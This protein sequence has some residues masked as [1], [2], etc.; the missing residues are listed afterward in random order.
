MFIDGWP[1][2][3]WS[4]VDY[5]RIPK[6]GFYALKQA[7][8]P[9]LI[10]IENREEKVA[11]GSLAN[12][13]ISIVNDLNK[14]FLA[15]NWS[16]A[17]KDPQGKTLDEFRGEVNVLMDFVTVL[18]DALRPNCIWRVPQESE[19]GEYAAE[20]ELVSAQ[21]EILSTNRIFFSVYSAPGWARRY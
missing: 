5:Y 1:S 19:E 6:Q 2:I 18:G 15:A 9:V 14:E 12:F 16:L 11:I 8:Q 17:I 3:T 20:A 10:S 13:G 7:Y 4:V 21:G